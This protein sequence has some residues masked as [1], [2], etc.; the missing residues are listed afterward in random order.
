MGKLYIQ[1]ISR[2]TTYV[3]I[4][5]G[6]WLDVPHIIVLNNELYIVGIKGET[7]HEEDMAQESRDE[8]I[9]FV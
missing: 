4:P 9:P 5:A 8:T 1:K 7:G 3:P 6:L 2:E